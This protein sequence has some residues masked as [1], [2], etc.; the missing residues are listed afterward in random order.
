MARV[1]SLREAKAARMKDK[2]KK[3][4]LSLIPTIGAPRGKE[5]P[6]RASSK[7]PI[8]GHQPGKK[9]KGKERLEEV[10]AFDTWDRDSYEKIDPWEVLFVPAPP[11]ADSVGIN[12]RVGKDIAARIQMLFVREGLPWENASDVVRWCI[13]FGLGEVAKMI[14]DK[15]LATHFRMLKVI[16]LE[17]AARDKQLQIV[18]VCRRVEK[19]MI[20]LLKA[21]YIEEA[22]SI[23]IKQVALY[24]QTPMHDHIMK[25][26][27][28]KLIVSDK[29]RYIRKHVD[30]KI[31]DELREVARI[32]E[33]ALSD[34]Q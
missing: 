17:A 29:L 34:E 13:Q 31:E 7:K 33:P 12:V 15:E 24:E 25:R 20:E 8:K 5:G 2:V 11:S 3:G 4:G 14:G 6:S 21:G 26:E 9:Y 23:F 28:A 16:A 27:T 30:Y 10:Y 18:E 22:A 1:E 19:Q 32:D